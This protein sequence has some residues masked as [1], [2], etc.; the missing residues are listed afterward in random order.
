MEHISFLESRYQL[1]DKIE[2]TDMHPSISLIDP[3]ISTA[4]LL[5]S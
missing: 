4:K 3:H 2:E 1:L 5:I